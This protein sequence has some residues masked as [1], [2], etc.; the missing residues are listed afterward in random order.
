MAH[1]SGWNLDRNRVI[2]FGGVWG[3][4]VWGL[5]RAAV[6]RWALWGSAGFSLL[7]LPG[8]GIAYNWGVV[9]G[10]GQIFWRVRCVG[11]ANPT[12]QMPRD[13]NPDASGVRKS[14]TR[15]VQCAKLDEGSLM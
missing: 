11:S 1:D 5:F 4:D 12:L 7:T 10:G 13:R 15:R 2:F 9:F 14:Q 3:A 8:G 6:A